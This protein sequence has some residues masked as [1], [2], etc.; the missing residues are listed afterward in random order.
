VDVG[1]IGGA[2]IMKVLSPLLFSTAVG[3]AS[4]SA[5]ASAKSPNC[6]SP[7]NWPT[8]MAFTYMKNAGITNNDQLDFT[9]TRT[10]RLASEKIGPDLYRQVHLVAFQQKD[11]HVLEAITVNDASSDECSMS[12]VQVFVVS[13]DLKNHMIPPSKSN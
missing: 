5:A 12:D 13:K 11:G 9:K 6:A 10:E 7:K 3:V 1:G 2:N 4:T 8:S